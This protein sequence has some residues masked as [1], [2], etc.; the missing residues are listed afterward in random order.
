MGRKMFWRQSLFNQSVSNDVNNER[1]RFSHPFKNKFNLQSNS[2]SLFAFGIISSL[3]FPTEQH[4]C[5]CVSFSDRCE[6]VNKFFLFEQRLLRQQFGIRLGAS[7]VH[8]DSKN[9]S[10]TRD[11]HDGQVMCLL[12]FNLRHADCVIIAA[13]SFALD[14]W[15]Q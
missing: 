2:T 13:L 8:R 7:D 15:P 4:S 6:V 12:R 14:V 11:S 1:Q 5:F 9:A 3:L 10:G